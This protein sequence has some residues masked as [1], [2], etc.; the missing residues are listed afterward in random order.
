[1]PDNISNIKL[2]LFNAKDASDLAMIRQEFDGNDISIAYSQI[3]GSV[4]ER[5]HK[6]SQGLKV[7]NNINTDN[8]LQMSDVKYDL[9]IS[10]YAKGTDSE[11]DIEWD[12]LLS[13]IKENFIDLGF[14]SK[15]Q[16]ID[17][18]R[19]LFNVPKDCTIWEL[20]DR[21]WIVLY[22]FL[23]DWT[24]RREKMVILP[25]FNKVA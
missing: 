4:K 21:H 3:S 1:M 11:T 8:S 19:K 5:I 23:K 24:K 10:W 12:D 9:L 7:E 13:S 20:C 16:R 15:Q 18:V 22:Y 6:L 14:L 17:Y 2:R 25:C